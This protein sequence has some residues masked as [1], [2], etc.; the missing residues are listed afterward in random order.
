MPK[1]KKKNERITNNKRKRT[2]TQPQ[3]YHA[4]LQE[5]HN[6]SSRMERK[7]NIQLHLITYWLFSKW[8]TQDSKLIQ[9]YSNQREL[10][11]I[12]L[13]KKNSSCSMNVGTNR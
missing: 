11:W 3:A 9:G 2:H 12:R 4:K 10:Q 13:I 5:L 6:Q 8:Y 7:Q 1:W